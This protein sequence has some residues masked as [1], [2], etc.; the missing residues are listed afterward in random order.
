LGDSEQKERMVCGNVSVAENMT[1]VGGRKNLQMWT[2]VSGNILAG[3]S[4]ESG[5]PVPWVE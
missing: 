3:F 4:Q 2:E 1:S 5:H